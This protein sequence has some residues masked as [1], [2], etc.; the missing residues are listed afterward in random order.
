MIRNPFYAGAYV[1]GRRP[2]RVAMVEGK[3]V[4]TLEKLRP[5]EQ[6]RVFIADHHDKYIS[7]QQYQYNMKILGRNGPRRQQSD[8]VTAARSGAGLLVGLLRC[9][10]CGRKLSVNYWGRTGTSPRYECR[11]TYEYAGAGCF[12]FSGK[13]VDKALEK[14]ILAAISPLGVEASI[15]AA[16]T[17]RDGGK[18]KLGVLTRRAQQLRYQADRAFDQ[19]DASDPKNRLVSAELERRWN[20]KLV[21][22]QQAESELVEAEKQHAKLDEKTL[23]RLAH[24]GKYFEQAWKSN[25]CNNQAKKRIIR[26]IIEEIVVRRDDRELI[27]I[28]HWIG[29]VHTEL[30]FERPSPG[31]GSKTPNDAIEIIRKLAPRY[32]DTK[33]AAVLS[34]NGMKTGR[35]NN[36][37]AARVQRVRRQ[38]D[39]SP[40]FVNPESLGL[41]T[42][43][44]A[45]SYCGIKSSAMY[46]LIKSG[47]IHNQQTVPLA[48]MEISKTELDSPEVQEAIRRFRV[49]GRLQ[50]HL[51]GD[52]CKNQLKLF[53]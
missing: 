12:G 47:L 29:G 53:K 20:D 30:R 17:V 38:Y 49:S 37:N 46:T 51:S 24:L 27:L 45:V 7:W 10:N 28:V 11:G 39:I 18:E 48:P 35:G 14:Q 15:V 3:L 42:M 2:R 4:K 31:C 44:K 50:L 9:G 22:A 19:Y 21:A 43:K 8:A 25:N 32:D 34:R 41:L 33:I 13:T 26:T 23:A 36:W 16:D 52:F 5:A 40:E 6:C 1:Y